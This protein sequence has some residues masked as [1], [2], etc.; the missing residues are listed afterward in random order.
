MLFETVSGS[1]YEVDQTNWQIRRISNSNGAKSTNRQGDGWKKFKEIS[2]VE[3]GSSVLITW[4]KTDTALLPNSPDCAIPA[5]L[6]SQVVL[7]H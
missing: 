5:T 6:T 3:V 1:L 2:N 7:I 4:D